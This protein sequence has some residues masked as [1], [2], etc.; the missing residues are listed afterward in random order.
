MEV[1]Y[2]S[3]SACPPGMPD[4]R[5]YQNISSRVYLEG[6]TP[7][8][9]LPIVRGHNGVCFHIRQWAGHGQG[10]KRKRGR[11]YGGHIA[12]LRP[13]RAHMPNPGI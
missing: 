11:A 9:G 13:I 4:P 7:L 5:V 3:L 12:G 8:V 10:G 1:A 2:S 6:D